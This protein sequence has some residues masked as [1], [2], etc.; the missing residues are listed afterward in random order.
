VTTPLRARLRRLRFA[1]LSAAAMALILLGILA[2]LTQLAMPWLEH[3]PQHVEHW[4]SQRLQR[5]VH[6]GGVRGTWVGGG[7][8]LGLD[9]VRIASNAPGQPGFAIA[10]AELA[11]NLF[12]PFERNGAFSEFRLAELGVDLVNE[13][14]AWHVRGLDL[15]P[16]AADDAPFSMGALGAIEI[17][18]LRLGVEDA[19]RGLRLALSV[20]VM[21][22]LNR[23]DVTRVLGRLRLHGSTSP[24]LDLAADLD[25][26]TRSGRIYVGGRSLDLAAL[27]LPGLPGGIR[28]TGG[29]GLA[30]FWVAVADARVEDVRARVDVADARFA[31]AAPLALDAIQVLPRVAFDRLAFAARWRRAADGWDFDLADLVADRNALTP[32]ARLSIERR[33]ADD[34][35]QWRAGTRGL[36]IEPLGSLA[37]LDG[38]VPA[39]LRRWLYLAHP[40]GQLGEATLRWNGSGDNA[41]DA[42]LRGASI[43]SSGFA[44]GIDRVDVDIHGDAQA[45]L[46]ELPEQA[47]R[48]DYP[49]VFRYP[50]LFTRFGGDVV[51]RRGEDGWQLATDRLVFDAEGFGGEVRGS[52]DLPPGRRPLVDLYAATTHGDVPAA[53]LFWPVNVMPP[54][55]V[56][57]LD[58]ALVAGSVV[59]GR[60][61]LHG[62]LAEWPFHGRGG[63]LVA[64]GELVDTVLDYSPE[65]PRAEKIHA[66]A[67][68]VN[69]GMQVD[70][71]AA[72]T[73]GNSVD[74]AHASI[75]DFGPLV[76]QL[77]AK[78]A[79]SGADLLAFLRATPVGRRYQEPLKTLAVGGKG[80]LAL[81]LTLPIHALD[82]LVLEGS[83]S[84]AGARID[85]GA[86]DLHFTDAS[87]PL[88]FNQKGFAADALDVTFRE[89]K[90]KLSVAVGGY[91]ADPKHAFEA[92]LE[93][94]F[95]AATVFAD[96]PALLPSLGRATGEASWNAAVGVDAGEAGATAAPR[97]HLALASDLSGIAIDLPP[98]L[99]KGASEAW[100]FRLDLDLPLAGQT[101][102]ARLGDVARINGHLP[103]TGRAFAARIEFGSDAA[104]EPS[105]QGIS[106]GGR[107]RSLDAGAWLDLV[108]HGS[109]GAGGLVQGIDVHADDFLFGG[110]HFS[111]QH[112]LIANGTA[113]T[114]VRL[115]GEALAGSL[116]IPS[117]D[118]A[119]RGIVASFERIHWPEAP[120]DAPD[121]GAFAEVVPASLPP[122]HLTV[123]DF[124]LGSASFGTARF[125]SHPVAGGMQVDTL[126]SHS[127][128]VTMRAHGD[129]TGSA[130]ENRS[131]LSIELDAQSLG[132]MM[133]AL[134]FPGLIDGGATKATIEA[135]YA[136][137]P[138]AFAL[139]RLDGSL[140]I[141]V[142]EGRILD[143][144]PGVGRLFG[145]FSLT[146]IP[147]RLSLDFTDFFRS[148]LGFNSITGTF[149]LM[150]G[151]AWTD[152]LTIKSP[153]ADIV[154][155]GRTGLRA[156]DYDQQMVV[157]PHAGSTL[158]IV[159]ALAAG[160]VGAAAGLVMQGI[161]NKPLGKAIARRY[162]VTGSWDKPKI[163]QVA[164]GAPAL[165][166][167]R[168]PEAPAVPTAPAAPENANPESAGLR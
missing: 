157:K 25:A 46:L 98:P 151:N 48:I 129:W 90:A 152:G 66:V 136:G 131:R 166:A 149:R 103:G 138:S 100:P 111:D 94:R 28:V 51:A 153:A 106:V 146:E 107:M 115:D 109:G 114:T 21:R 92:S 23:G 63:R 167:A 41:I 3:H 118:L 93:G 68:F 15:Q 64:R 35:V 31:S 73:L 158:P 164:R 159:G 133:D 20:P 142:A 141:Q 52:V 19:Q 102:T 26:S 16:S 76:L 4:L 44:P 62:D 165:P 101:F 168:M 38:R 134:G 45:I 54:S 85:H 132:R 37:M 155:T 10:H 49:R 148:G 61:A 18:N 53:K 33:G 50:F 5:A 117:A 69:D 36:P 89:R 39:A 105:A 124:R 88:R 84:L 156:K 116:E 160:P 113:A 147:R 140:A 57:W 121:A 47:L 29:N 2:G 162:T 14:G 82:T 95:P 59:D 97:T 65:W 74:E 81:A 125:D 6:V 8:L 137:P 83:A 67:Q 119:T 123:E 79:G 86:Y 139:P 55:A 150:D 126:E 96:V 34:A 143:V 120:A 71:S 9:D 12:A 127:P 163:T 135:S 145:L 110:R 78:A 80:T 154:V 7:P 99:H 128:N 30:Q 144:Q 112:L 108:D 22:L 24:L 27:A 161:L 72:Q 130:Q 122:L 58:R 91:V 17:S 77:D 43:A 32:P 60:I 70:A 42:S 40:R 56:E 87:G 75:P 1:L 13:G 11:F 104:P